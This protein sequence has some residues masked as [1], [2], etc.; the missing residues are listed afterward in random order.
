VNQVRKPRYGDLLELE[1]ERI[2]ERGRARGHA[3]DAS[4]VYDVSVRFALPGER[5]R[6]LVLTRRR[7][8]IEGL[9]RERIHQS[10]HAVA[11]R[12]EHFGACGGCSFQDLDYARQ[13]EEKRAI[14]IE[15]L[16]AAALVERG[17]TR[18]VEPCAG[19]DE[20]WRYRNKMDFT[21]GTRRWVETREPP[22]A[23][24]DFALGLHPREQFKKVLDVRSC[25]IQF[26]RGDAIL[27]SAR[28]IALEQ[29]LS[30]WD[31]ISHT[32]LLRHLVLRESRASGE[33]LV[34][35]VTSS[36]SREQ[37]APY[38]AAM[39][40]AHPEIT[41]VV[42]NINSRPAAIA[43]G[44]REIAWHGSGTIR[45]RLAGFEFTV[46]ANSFFQTNTAQAEK[47]VAMVV[48]AAASE[49]GDVVF[50]VYCGA[51]ALSLP[52]A[53]DASEVIGFELAPTAVRDAELNASNNGVANVR[54]IAGD[55]V[56]SLRAP[57]LPQPSVIVIDPP[58]AG[59]HPDVVATLAA[60][61]ARR[62]VYVSCNLRAAARD[63]ALLGASGWRIARAQPLDLFPHTPHLECVLSLTCRA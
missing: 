14:A 26:E 54:F 29:N 27:S 32:G 61:S 4:G 34:D 28:R 10:P 39:L 15:I 62:M 16:R 49:P 59:L 44:E 45:E 19:C 47:L 48:A 51:G 9:V 63:I 41:T 46:S 2:D 58:R 8:R 30:A 11:P 12:C 21:F 42:Q 36:E 57:E 55:V 60:R 35:I 18:I 52:L 40:A 7:N 23:P 50:D 33:I 38:V 24:R 37:V 6:A 25:P 13:L 20:P 5:V 3:S 31:L 53:R 22:D 17:D 56:D 1:I 43:I